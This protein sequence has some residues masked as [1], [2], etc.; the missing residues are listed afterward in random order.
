MSAFLHKRIPPCA[1]LAGGSSDAAST[2]M[3][4]N[5]VWKLGWTRS[6]LS[7]F[8]AQFGS[9][10]SFFFAETG[11]AICT[12]RGEIVRPIARPDICRWAILMLPNFSMSTPDVYRR[13]D[14]M[15]LGDE[16][17]IRDEP[18]WLTWTKLPAAELMPRLIN[19]LEPPA[20]SLR[21]QLGELRG[22]LETKLGRVFRM[23]GS[24]S[25]LFSLC[26]RFDEAESLRRGAKRTGRPRD[27]SR[28]RADGDVG[29][30]SDVTCSL[31]RA[32]K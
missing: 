1:G 20:F 27:R 12:S 9:D 4:L 18:D 19:D 13:F 14:E 3:A 2:L 24:G 7:A 23:S 10:L 15:Q 32:C 30:D 29:D 11:S 5:R 8:A 17:S 16:R 31:A 28:D 22:A 26:D 25:S 6:R 21:P